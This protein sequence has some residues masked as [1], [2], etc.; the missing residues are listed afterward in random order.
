V[1]VPLSRHAVTNHGVNQTAAVR[2]NAK[3]LGKNPSKNLAKNP[4]KNGRK[5]IARHNRSN[6]RVTSSRVPLPLRVLTRRARAVLHNRHVTT[7]A[8]LRIC[9]RFCYAR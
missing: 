3:N 4:A 9:R 2:N 1:N 8:T 6:N 7:T 5:R